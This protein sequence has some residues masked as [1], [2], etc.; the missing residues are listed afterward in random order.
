MRQIYMADVGDG[1]C[2]GIHTLFNRVVQI[3][4]GGLAR[5]WINHT[6]IVTLDLNP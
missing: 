5:A 1:L 3:D 2:V 6:I 4:C